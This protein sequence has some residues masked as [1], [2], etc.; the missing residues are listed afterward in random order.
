MQRARRFEWCMMEVWFEEF[1]CFPNISNGNWR[2]VVKN[3]RSGGGRFSL[4][5]LRGVCATFYCA[6]D[7]FRSFSLLPR[8]M[9][10]PLTLWRINHEGYYS[11]RR[12][13]IQ[14][15]RLK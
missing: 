9:F 13:G 12:D 3:G 2:M 5:F 8:W 10:L 14:L 1:V 7:V 15:A 6:H 4:T 11:A